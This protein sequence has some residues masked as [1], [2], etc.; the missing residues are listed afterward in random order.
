[1]SRK[2]LKRKRAPVVYPAPVPPAVAP[3][4]GKGPARLLVVAGVALAGLA[5]IYWL[6]MR[7]SLAEPEK[8]PVAAKKVD[9]VPEVKNGTP[10]S[11][12]QTEGNFLEDF[13]KDLSPGDEHKDGALTNEELEQRFQALEKIKN[14]QQALAERVKAWNDNVDQK[15]FREAMAERKRLKGLL[16]TL[17]SSLEKEIARAR[18]ARPADPVVRWLTAELMIYVGTEPELILPHLHDALKGGLDR[19]RLLA[20]LARTEAEANQLT[21]AYVTGAKALDRAGQDRY[22]WRAYSRNAFH[23]EKFA[24]VIERLDSAF[25]EKRPDWANVM[26][27]NAIDF[28]AYWQVEQR[29]RAADEKADLPRVRLVVE[30]RRFQRGPKGEATGKTESTGTGEFIVELFEDQA[31]ATVANFIVLTEQKTY[32][33]TR[34]HLAESASLVAGG[35][36]QSKSGDP[37]DDGLG[38]PG[39]VIPDECQLPAARRHFRGS[40]SM[41]KTDPHTAGSQFFITLVPRP[42]MD[43]NFTVFGRVIN[44]MEVVDGITRGRTNPNV[45]SHG[46]IIPGDLLIRAEV[47]R[48]RK[49]EYRVIK[50]AGK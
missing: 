38:G 4:P 28:L 45:G 31:P 6:F 43:G 47:V 27:R 48:K 14:D 35:D 41:V 30:H 10:S 29:Q 42:D 22:V 20:S 23:V 11:K 33:G 21:K 44:G 26:R 46:L 15:D 5:L 32:D 34:F 19:P 12:K 40:L 39:Y 13:A 8:V 7:P 37:K 50:E 3:L 16:D 1:M 17:P 18:K 2:K 9:E 49:H 36:P 25:P 24:E